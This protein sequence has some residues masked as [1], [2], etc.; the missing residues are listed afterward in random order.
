MSESPPVI[1]T[2]LDLTERETIG[3][4]EEERSHRPGSPVLKS[5]S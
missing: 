3:P 4:G 1:P 5:D 2:P